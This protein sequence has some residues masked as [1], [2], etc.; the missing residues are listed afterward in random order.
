MTYCAKNKDCLPYFVV[1]SYLKVS[2]SFFRI[3]ISK[4]HE[5]IN[6]YIMI[7]Y[8]VAS[9]LVR[10]SQEICFC[11]VVAGITYFLLLLYQI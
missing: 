3:S 9:N 2:F 4:F 11:D 10:Q 1:F 6:V 7:T 8:V 5:V